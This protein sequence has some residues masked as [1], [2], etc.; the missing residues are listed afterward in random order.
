MKESISST[1]KSSETED[2]FDFH[3]VRPMGYL[4]AKLFAKVNMH[5][6]TVT[7]ISMII[8]AVSCFFFANGSCH[9]EQSAGFWMNIVGVLLL[10]WAYVYDC[11][12]GQLARMTGK[13]SKLGRILDGAAGYAWYIPIYAALIYRFYNH[14]DL[15][16][17]W[18]GITDS[19]TASVIAA[20]VAFA[21]AALSGIVCLA[22]QQR[23]ADYY[24]QVH[25]FFLKGEKGSELDNSERQRQLYDELP[26]DA[27]WYEREF[28]K[29]YVGYTRKQEHATP[30][31][32]RLM[33][34]LKEKF[35]SASAMPEQ[36]RREFHDSSLR[37]ITLNGLLTFNFRS[38]WFFLFC[39]LDVPVLNFLF[40]IIV[41]GLLCHYVIHRYERLSSRIADKL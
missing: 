18:L 32:Q 16:F 5:P 41:M 24:I 19:P 14:H 21:L 40:E 28:Q 38:F 7:V 11:T 31:F 1:L 34:L 12:D 37:I 9:Y 27:P 4:W 25:L 33:G 30:Q 15:E 8:G 26:K 17:G 23:T 36:V 20:V 39:L 35:G 22:G 2:W 3:V 13:K 10:F 6:N 29:S